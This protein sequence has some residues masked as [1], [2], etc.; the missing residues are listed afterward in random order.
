VNEDL[1]RKLAHLPTRPG[2]YQHRDEAGI[3]LYVGKAKN[4]RSRVNSYFHESRHREGRLRILVSK[5]R[6]VDVIVTDTEAEALLLENNLIKDLRP[7]YNI[8]LRDDKTYPYICIK[9]EPFPRVF[10]TRTVRKDGSRYF[11]PYTDVKNMRL[12]L[13]TIRSVFR[14]RTCSLNL[15]PEPIAASKYDVCLQ[16]HIKKC[17]GPCVGLE[18][19][20]DYDESIRQVEQLLNGKTKAL[21]A[22]LKTAMDE[23]AGNM[24]FEEAARLRDQIQA[25]GK[26]TERQ[27][28][29]S[30]D[31]VDRDLFALAI[32]DESGIAGAA[33]VQMREGNVI[34]RQ[35][36]FLHQVQG[37][38]PAELLQ[39]VVERY[40]TETTFFP[41]EIFLDRELDNPALV[42]AF[43]RERRGARVTLHVPQRGDK[44]GLI[45]M[46]ARNAELI[47]EEYL[48]QRQK[49]NEG[50][51]P[52]TVTAL[53]QDLSLP[54]LP[55][56]LECFDIS[57]LGGTNVVAS[58]VVFVD[59]KPR[60]SEYR[61][62]KVR[63]VGGGR[64]DD[65]QSMREVVGR[66]YGKIVEENGPW[67]DLVVIDGGKGQV[68]S[69]VDALKSVE[70]YG[71]FPIVGIAKRL[72]EVFFPGDTEARFIPK[73]SA[74]LQ[75]LQR[76]RNEA[77]RFAVTFQRKQ[78][79]LTTL[80]TELQDIRG[81]GPKTAQTL[82]K[83]FGSVK[84]IRQASEAA[85]VEVVGPHAARLVLAHFHE[86]TRV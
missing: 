6:D 67:P 45:R 20:E 44:A 61:T 7:R 77:H 1:A 14:L 59:G 10:P 21:T 12:M 75:L 28:V 9:N 13:E 30:G 64:S 82:M 23:A 37:I 31:F 19:E 33:I 66:R 72:E 63:S 34:A 85:L 70:A 42:E 60:K 78:R 24:Q 3:V 57:H 54:R 50:K 35:K 38:A 86:N 15:S 53:K 62:Y 36:K 26:Y 68:S 79:T 81:V 71:R 29:M 27:K 83:A 11:G 4:L 56:R 80:H 43:V 16:Y 48:L 58:C 84:R 69:A 74:S 47:L 65:F 2:V 40:Y 41:E 22:R 25:L 5:I 55:R 51:I 52:H 46:V 39:T 76:A 73:S 49:A 18:S 8:L 32:D 17:N